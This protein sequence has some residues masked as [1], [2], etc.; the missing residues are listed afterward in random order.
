MKQTRKRLFVTAK[1]SVREREKMIYLAVENECNT[2]VFSLNDRYFK[3]PN[4]NQKY[5]K[6]INNQALN[7]E[8]GGYDFSL[9]MPKKSF[10]LKRDLFRMH[11]GNRKADHHFCPTNPETI[12]IITENAHNLF[13]AVIEK[14]ASPRIFHLFPDKGFETT[15]CACPACRAFSPAEQYLI[16]VNTAADALAKIDTDARIMYIDFD[17]EPDA[18]GIS[19]KPNVIVSDK[20]ALNI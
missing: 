20:S 1:T 8:A 6:L 13:S 7:I 5:I 16:A 3:N 10:F 4:K 18:E 19:P 12:S 14:L 11:Q 15:W 2:V 17:T 9:V